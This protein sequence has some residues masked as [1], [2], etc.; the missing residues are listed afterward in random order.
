MYR[1]I[2]KIGP[3]PG[4]TMPLNRP[5]PTNANYPRQPTSNNSNYPATVAEG[6]PLLKQ[7]DQSTPYPIHSINQNYKQAG[8]MSF[9]LAKLLNS[10]RSNQAIF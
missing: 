7:S 4:Q 10:S 8:T 6:F 2:C 9:S 5:P 3:R 1:Y